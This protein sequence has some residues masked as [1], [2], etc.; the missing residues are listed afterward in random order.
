MP[1]VSGHDRQFSDRR[2]RCEVCGVRLR[3]PA[4]GRPRVRCGKERC[5]NRS[6]QLRRALERTERA[7]WRLED[8]AEA[9]RAW[10][11]K[12]A[13]CGAG[14]RLLP[15]RYHLAPLPCCDECQD[16]RRQLSIP[17][18]KLEQIIRFVQSSSPHVPMPKVRPL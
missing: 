8:F 1:Q 11:G 7:R 5:E 14:G 9:L 12:C 2:V 6:R 13:F 3:Q 17:K 4:E 18:A 15:S 16:A 10:G